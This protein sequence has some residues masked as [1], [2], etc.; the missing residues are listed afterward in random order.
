MI[1]TF[2]SIMF[3]GC[4][5]F[6][7]V[8]QGWVIENQTREDLVIDQ[9]SLQDCKLMLGYQQ[10]IVSAG[11]Q[12]VFSGDS[13]VICAKGNKYPI[14]NLTLKTLVVFIQERDEPVIVRLR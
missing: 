8:A 4:V 6:S 3:V 7:S 14:D 13:C 2:K 10:R 12:L 11:E 9:V 5:L 1:K